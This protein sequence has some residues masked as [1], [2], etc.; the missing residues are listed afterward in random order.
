MKTIFIILDGI[1]DRPCEQ[2]KGKTPLEAAET[3]NLN[4]LTKQG[5]LGSM[6]PKKEDFAPESDDALA[7]IFGYDEL[8]AIR[9]QL[10]TIGAGIKLQEGDLALRTNF[11]TVNN[12]REGKILDRRAGRTLTTKEATILAKTINSKVKLPVK[13]LFRN[14]IQHRGVLVFRGG[15]SDNITNTDPAYRIKGSYAVHDT[16][17]YSQSLDEDENSEYSANILNQFIEKSYSVL[18]YHPI[19][20]QRIKK[21]LPPANIILTRDADSSL[22]PIQKLEGKWAAIV[23][24]PLE[25]GLSKLLGM[26]IFSFKYPEMKEA[27]VYRNLYDGL[28]TAIK[29]SKKILQNQLR[30]YDYFYIHFKETDVPGHDNLPEEKKKMIEI[31]DR[32]FFASLRLLAAKEKI[33]I[34][35][36]ADHAVPCSLKSHSSDAVP[37]LI[38]GEGADSTEHFSEKEALKGSIGKIYGK[39]LMKLI[40]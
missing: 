32:D 20:L 5:K 36:T 37:V 34:V 8:Y 4:W 10:E 7:S 33:K 6:I 25:I 16:L 26:D 24:M 12:I 13:F 23:Y 11:A 30:N 31:L 17:H 15:M 3:P 19:N 18:A 28:N 29:F 14:T 27:N 1:G 35:V 21:K 38:Y 39:D 22:P 9:G 40:K 2:L